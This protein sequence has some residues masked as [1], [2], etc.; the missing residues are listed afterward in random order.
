[1]TQTG[2]K[3]DR[4]TE[5]ILMASVAFCEIVPTVVEFEQ[6]L[7]SPGVDDDPRIAAALQQDIA[8]CVQIRNAS[9]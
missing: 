4:L 5:T 1:V 8:T 3:L 2:A 7:R 9:R 6:A